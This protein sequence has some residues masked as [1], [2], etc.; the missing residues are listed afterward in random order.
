MMASVAAIHFAAASILS[1]RIVASDIIRR[2]A[3]GDTSLLNPQF[4]V[5]LLIGSV[6]CVT[7]QIL[8]CLG[9]GFERAFTGYFVGLLWYVACSALFF[10]RLLMAG[11]SGHGTE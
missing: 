4:I 8:N 7:I 11:F 10:V 3:S 9:I 2:V 6:L 1:R 5:F